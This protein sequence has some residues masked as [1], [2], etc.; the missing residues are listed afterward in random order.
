[1]KNINFGEEDDE[2]L[3]ERID[4]T[5][6]IPINKIIKNEKIEKIDTKKRKK[7]KKDALPDQQN[8]KENIP[9]EEQEFIEFVLMDFRQLEELNNFSNMKSLS[10]IQQNIKNISVNFFFQKNKKLL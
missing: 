4:K 5:N 2:D 1:M 9:L 7:Y 8:F 3:E 6:K 10:L